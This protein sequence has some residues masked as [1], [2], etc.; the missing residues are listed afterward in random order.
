M[1]VSIVA[2]VAW[3]IEFALREMIKCDDPQALQHLHDR[4]AACREEVLRSM[5]L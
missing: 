2:L 3:R 1:S 5:P 4:F